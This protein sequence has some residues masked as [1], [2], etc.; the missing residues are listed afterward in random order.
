MESD[1]TD[2]RKYFTGN[3]VFFG[4]RKAVFP[5][6][7][8]KVKEYFE[9]EEI[10]EVEKLNLSVDDVRRMISFVNHTSESKKVVMLSSFYWQ[11]EAQNAMLKVLE[12][13]PANTFIY[14]FGLSE[15]NFLKTV[16]SR[17]QK[18]SFKNTNRYLKIASDILKLDPND[19]P[20]QKDVKK[21]LA[22]KVVDYNFDKD[23][24]NEKKDRESHILFLHALV[25][26]Y[27]ESLTNIEQKEKSKDLLEK[28][29]TISTM[30]EIEGGSPHLFIDWLL[31]TLPKVNMV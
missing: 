9:S 8:E 1:K 10:F 31:L 28:I 19:R 15:K 11:D 13:T 29:V 23:T 26:V 6:V 4:D 5:I 2:I 20:D 21:I 24:E 18:V 3:A 22:L 7:K 25:T 16:L 14:L 17:V 27:L 12:E 30:A